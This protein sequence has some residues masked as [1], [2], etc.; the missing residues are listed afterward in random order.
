MENRTLILKVVLG[1]VICLLIYLSLWP[2]IKNL[3]NSI[4]DEDYE[5]DT[6]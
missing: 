5:E 4:D 6:S 2:V 3:V 1:I